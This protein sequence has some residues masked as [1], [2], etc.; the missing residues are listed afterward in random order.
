MLRYYDSGVLVKLY[1]R[2]PFSA[3]AVQTVTEAGV[4]I[5]VNALQ[6]L[7]VANAIR[8]KAFRDEIT[9]PE[10]EAA[11]RAMAS[12]FECGRLRRLSVD[13][14][15]AFAKALELSAGSTP[16]VGCRSLD[17]L[18]VAVAL[19]QGCSELVSMDERQMRAAVGTGLEVV[20]IREIG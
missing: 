7:E 20:D 17:I 18:H 3:A 4:G 14:A 2:E 11:L 10:Q 16:E 15:P 6:E 12:D 9:A 5:H 19:Q 13:W 1:V 8:L